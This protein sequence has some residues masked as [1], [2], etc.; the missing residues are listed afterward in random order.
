MGFIMKTTWK[1]YLLQILIY[2]LCLLINYCK[3]LIRNI[4]NHPNEDILQTFLIT[5]TEVL[6]TLK[7]INY[8]K[9]T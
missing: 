5:L 6:T 9:T 7:Q 4:A 3:K 8:S 2:I 1:I